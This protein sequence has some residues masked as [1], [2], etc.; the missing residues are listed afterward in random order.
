MFKSS[1]EYSRDQNLG[2]FSWIGDDYF[3]RQLNVYLAAISTH[4]VKGTVFLLLIHDLW[5]SVECE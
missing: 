2:V 3:I 1:S 4:P 5:V